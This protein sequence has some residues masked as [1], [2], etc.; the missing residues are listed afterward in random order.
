MS[1]TPS[2]PKTLTDE[3]IVTVRSRGRRSFLSRVGIAVAASA[4]IVFGSGSSYVAGDIKD[5][6]HG[7]RDKKGG[8]SDGKDRTDFDTNADAKN[9]D[10][11]SDTKN[12]DEGRMADNH[13]PGD[14]TDGFDDPD[15]DMRKFA[16]KKDSD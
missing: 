13:L 4:A 3:D 5:R 6:D 1:N 11:R 10:G 14:R 7:R 2:D 15:T 12:S 9:T 8:D 16:D